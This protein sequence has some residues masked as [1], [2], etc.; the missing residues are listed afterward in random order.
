MYDACLLDMGKEGFSPAAA[1]RACAIATYEA[2]GMTPENPELKKK[3][4]SVTGRAKKIATSLSSNPINIMKFNGG[5]RLTS[6]N[7]FQFNYED[8][9]PGAVNPFE[10]MYIAERGFQPR[11]LRE[12][13]LIRKGEFNGIEF[14]DED[15][16]ALIDNW[17]RPIPFQIDHR[18]DYQSNL[19]H[20]LSVR[21]AGSRVYGLSEVIGYQPIS[22][23][24]SGKMKEVSIGFYLKPRKLIEFSITKFPAV[25]GKDPAQ[26]LNPAF[27]PKKSRP[28]SNPFYSHPAVQEVLHQLPVQDSNETESF[29][30][31]TGKEP[32]RAI[33]R[34]TNDPEIQNHEGG[35]PEEG[36]EAMDGL[37]AATNPNSAT[38]PV[39]G[40]LSMEMLQAQFQQQIKAV[41]DQLAAERKEKEE[42]STRLGA[43]E[44]TLK[45]TRNTG[46]VVEFARK[47]LTTPDASTDELSFIGSLSDD[48]LSK[49]QALKEKNG[50]VISVAKLSTPEIK[51]PGQEQSSQERGEQKAR[52][53]S[54]YAKQGGVK[55]AE[56]ASA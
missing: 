55:K 32:E 13:F 29:A 19:G 9:D 36:Q 18:T 49:Y 24:R 4:G 30:D 33:I 50:P 37:T 23:I 27:D 52:L 22:E 53:S 51:E 17:E 25:G 54:G 44:E 38:P 10:P 6:E 31:T 1:A 8:G 42:L 14:T 41:Q 28:D 21:K 16:Q 7:A 56:T 45:L 5:F 35:N 34:L 40:N 43:T 47:G 48:Q 46:I 2:T 12:V 15:L 11:M 20:L 26:I 3:K 39:V